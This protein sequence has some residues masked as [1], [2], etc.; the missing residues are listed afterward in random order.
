MASERTNSNQAHKRKAF[1]N[2]GLA[3]AKWPQ[4]EMMDKNQEACAIEADKPY[5]G[6]AG[7]GMDSEQD[8][9]ST[10]QYAF[11]V[12]CPH[13]HHWRAREMDYGESF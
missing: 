10:S 1:K 9:P 6:I 11:P 7:E 5:H 8:Q 13:G 12:Q 2:V 3:I 4:C